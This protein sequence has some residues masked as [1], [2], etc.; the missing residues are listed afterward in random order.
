MLMR[1]ARCL[2]TPCLPQPIM[3]WDLR[4]STVK[5][6][7]LAFGPPY[8]FSWSWHA[9]G[10]PFNQMID[11]RTGRVGLDARSGSVTGGFAGSVAAHVGLTIQHTEQRA[12][13][14]FLRTMFTT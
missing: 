12:E 10:P 13:W 3:R 5:P 8:N 7:T 1:L 9:G 14:C 4:G 6:L 2:A 11:P